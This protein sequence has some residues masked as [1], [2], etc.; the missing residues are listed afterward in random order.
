MCERA[1]VHACVCL[2]VRVCVCVC[3]CG[4]VCVC[5]RARTRVEGGR[6]GHVELHAAGEER[7]G[8]SGSGGLLK[9]ERWRRRIELGGED[10]GMRAGVGGVGCWTGGGQRISA[11]TSRHART[12]THNTHTHTHTRARAHTNLRYSIIYSLNNIS[13]G[14]CE[15]NMHSI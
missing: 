13:I 2:H 3:T 4:C 12:H 8:P 5:V 14:A 9:A 10:G 15:A 1:R 6:C 11:M 7:K